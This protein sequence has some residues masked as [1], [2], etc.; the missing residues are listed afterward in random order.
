MIAM[1]PFPIFLL[2]AGSAIAAEIK[3]EAQE[4][5]EKKIRPV[6]AA[7]CYECHGPTKRK[8]GLR[9]DYRDGLLEGGDTGP[10]VIA[11]DVEK[12]LLIQS[13]KHL[14]DDLK[15]PKNGAKL[16]GGI[17]ADFEKWVRMGAPD[18]RDKALTAAEASKDMDWTQV[19]KLRKQWWSFLPVTHPSPPA[20]KNEVWSQHPVDRFVLKKMEDAGL[21]PAKR[22][23]AGTLIR[24]ISFVLTGLPPSPEEVAAFEKSAI[25]NPQSAIESLV[26]R[27]LKSPRFGEKWARHWMDWVRYAES[28]G[29]EGDP[30]IPYASRYR[31][32]LI[33][34]FNA[35]VPYPQMLREAVAGDLLP[36]PRLNKDLGL[37]ESALGIAQLRMV[38]HG[39]SPVDTLDEMVTFTDNQIDV[40]SKAFQ[41]LTVT[42]AR[43]H[44]HKFD[45]ISQAD[46]YAMFGIFSSTHPAVIDAGLPDAGKAQ[47]DELKAL[48]EQIKAAVGKAWLQTVD[49]KPATDGAHKEGQM[50]AD[51]LDLKRWDLRKDKWF[52][53]GEGVKQGAT[54]AG[55]FSIAHQ[56]STF[57]SHIHSS[58]VFS[59]LIST[60]DRGVLM[61]PRLKCEGGTLWIR[62]AG[63]S[64]ARVRYIVDNYPRTG[65]IHKAKEFKTDPDGLLSWHKLDLDFWKGDEI[66]IQA[67]TVAD[68][69]AETKPDERSWFGITDA[70]ITKSSDTP[71]NVQPTG[72]PRLAIEAWM[73]NTLTDE[74]ADLLDSLLQAGKLPNDEKHLA[75]AAPLIAK[76]REIESKLP[77]PA[78]SPGVLEADGADASLFVRGDH[79][80][81]GEKVQRRFLEAIDARPYQPKNSGR[82][83]LAMS[84]TRADNPLTSRVIVNRLWHHVFGRGI[85]ATTDNFGRLGTEPTHPDL[86]DFLASSFDKNGGSIKEMLRLLITSQT[87]QLDHHASAKAAESDPENFLLSHASVRRL[88]AEAIRDSILACSGKMSDEMFGDSVG[89]KDTRRSIY[90]KVLRNNLDPLLTV[91]DMPVPSSTRG[92]RDATNVPAQSLTLLNDPT[93]IN[94]STAWAN[95]ILQTEAKSDD[96]RVTIMFTEAFG[97]KPSADEVKQS[98]TYVRALT[99][100][101]DEARSN[102]AHAEA[103]AAALQQRIEALL[104]PARQKLS[105]SD[106][107]AEAVKNAPTP[108]AEWDFK[109]GPRDLRGGMHLE[110]ED[111]ARIEGGALVLEGGKSCAVSTA[112]PKTLREKTLEAWVQLADLDQRGAGVLT[113]QTKNGG[114]FDSIVFGEKDPHCWIS[115]SNNFKRTESFNAP[116]EVIADKRPVHL[117]IV[118]KADGSITAYRQGQPYGQAYTKELM[119]FES[120]DCNIVLGMRH[121]P[122]GGNKMLR[123]RILRARV[124]DRALSAEEVKTSSKLEASAPSDE[125]VL[126]ALS[127]TDRDAV[128]RTREELDQLQTQITDL[129]AAT[130]NVGPEAAWRSL[131]QSLINLKEFIYLR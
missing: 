45:A 29:S 93:I 57:I 116:T 73:N 123:G 124:Y 11:G 4:F 60:N 97:R 72:D 32:Y 80:Q 95:R 25:Q 84:L 128:K 17:V 92:R 121:S 85:V 86:L 90:V 120:G 48:K 42:C 3:P 107:S 37:N 131:A 53:D 110:L 39:F 9:L 49:Q 71:P 55:E 35:D 54:K 7:E 8:A 112:L 15:M 13:I 102:L 43:C 83:E 36:S 100:G 91:F 117:A 31:D 62:A 64:G 77:Q 58:G 106:A 98:V 61:S 52:S 22:A 20:V 33:R 46:Y 94:W 63:G 81:P 19:L 101:S 21:E 44:N 5:F 1:R 74:Q 122:G 103:K 10:A 12:S 56:G 78:R 126:A 38:L 68:M 109:Q 41:G 105:K 125:D 14:H 65:T 6:L 75:D 18:P 24:R 113:V 89:S 88:E 127:Q 50:T 70:F 76:Y 114:I 23:D 28:Y 130:S 87:F 40:V 2:L 16:D 59:D 47:R 119:P 66:F 30:A 27:L 79:K 108:F 99:D 96:D 129:R 104:S 111:K 118:Y 26:D 67:T 69:A 34:A 51:P 82:L 115:G